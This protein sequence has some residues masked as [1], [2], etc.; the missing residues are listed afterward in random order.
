MKRSWAV[1]VAA[2]GVSAML[3]SA[4]TASQGFGETTAAWLDVQGNKSTVTAATVDAT[5]VRCAAIPNGLLGGPAVRISW[6]PAQPLRGASVRYRMLAVSVD[7]STTKILQTDILG[8]Q[9]DL[10]I[11]LLP[12]IVSGLLGGAQHFNVK[13]QV[14]QS[15]GG[16][17]PNV[18]ETPVA[19]ARSVSVDPTY[20]LNLGIVLTG[21]KCT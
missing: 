10:S 15:F 16:Q 14:L 19:Q 6:D 11:G 5:T 18:W 20:L 8:T 2:L 9:A 17:T 4:V 21:Y 3:F 7:G 1:R 12:A 13:I